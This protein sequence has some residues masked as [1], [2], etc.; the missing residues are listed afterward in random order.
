MGSQSLAFYFSV[1]RPLQLQ[2]SLSSMS[3]KKT[4]GIAAALL[5]S[6]SYA[7]MAATLKTSVTS[8]VALEAFNSATGV[9]GDG[10]TPASPSTLGAVGSATVTAVGNLTTTQLLTF[11]VSNASFAAAISSDVSKNIVNSCGVVSYSSGGTVGS[12]TVTFLV[13]ATGSPCAAGGTIEWKIPD[14]KSATGGAVTVSATLTAGSSPGGVNVDGGVTYAKSGDGDLVLF[15]D[16][17]KADAASNGSLVDLASGST[18]LTGTPT[19]TTFRSGA[20]TPTVAKDTTLASLAGKS[21]SNSTP[22]LVAASGITGTVT[23]SNIPSAVTKVELGKAGF[24]AFTDGGKVV[25]C[26]TPTAGSSTCSL[27]AAKMAEYSISTLI[28][29]FTVDGTTVIPTTALTASFT[30]TNVSGNASAV[31]TLFTS[32]TIA[33][34]GTN[35]CAAEFGSMMGKNTPNAL[36]TIR[37]SNSSTAAG[38]VFVTATD[39]KGTHSAVTQITKANGG[40]SATNVLN[41]SEQLPAGATIELLG[42]TLEA[43]TLGFDSWSGTTRGRVR[44]YLEATNAGDLGAVCKA[45]A[46]MCINGTCSIV[47]Q[48]GNGTGGNTPIAKQAN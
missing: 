17:H 9:L 2:G 19:A 35:G 37:L 21:F 15:A 43:A 1:F 36:T 34:L 30:A 31:D 42:T 12:N 33:T 16:A 29:E 23:I 38:R 40:A 26:S 6:G 18:K 27:N 25:T 44:V 10:S 4:A 22:A 32:K 39:D 7:A 45:E 13:D 5:L 47:N 48:T 20:I 46:W 24:T 28:A 3:L 11:T 14:L 8:T 41:S